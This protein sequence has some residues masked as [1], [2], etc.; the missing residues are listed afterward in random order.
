[1]NRQDIV[2]LFDRRNESWR[3]RDAAAL[4]ADHAPDAVAESPMQGRLVGRARIGEVYES[5]FKAFPDLVFTTRELLIDGNRVAQ[6][7]GVTGTQAAPFGGVPATGR[8][9]DFRGAWIYTLSPEG[10]ITH[11]ERLY[12]VTAVLVQL[13][14]LRAKPVEV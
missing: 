7:Y 9:I 10:L 2:T 14:A 6:I 1:M 4:A 3:Q 13:G 8:R 12:D 11:D 5:W